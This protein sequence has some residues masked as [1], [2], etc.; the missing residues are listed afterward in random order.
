MI[1]ITGAPDWQ[2]DPHLPGMYQTKVNLE[3]IPDSDGHYELVQDAWG[4]GSPAVYTLTDR[5]AHLVGWG[6]KNGQPI[7][8]ILSE[9]RP[10]LSYTEDGT[11]VSTYLRLR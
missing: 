11:V 8:V 4:S 6:V 9:T 3:S 2:P 7:A 1:K 10:S 5:M